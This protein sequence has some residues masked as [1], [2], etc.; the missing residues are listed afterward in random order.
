MQK[1]LMYQFLQGAP[2]AQAPL[3]RFPGPGL[4]F[5]LAP[6]SQKGAGLP[7][8]PSPT[9]NRDPQAAAI[10]PCF[11]DQCQHTEK[12]V[13]TKWLQSSKHFQKGI[14]D[15]SQKAQSQAYT[16]HVVTKPQS[17]HFDNSKNR[18]RKKTFLISWHQKS[19]QK[20][21]CK[22]FTSTLQQLCWD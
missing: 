12:R 17:W 3:S 1:A 4:G 11:S 8:V 7:K 5:G 6:G 16:T 21:I 20:Y 18:R 22:P 15:T 10:T 13:Q 9:A 14:S 2:A 19:V